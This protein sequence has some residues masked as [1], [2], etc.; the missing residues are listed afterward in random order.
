MQKRE[1]RML[2]VSA[3]R[4]LRRLAAACGAVA[5][6]GSV[7]AF[8]ADHGAEGS[9]LQLKDG[10]KKAIVVQ[11][12]DA[13]AL[14]APTTSPATVGATVELTLT[15]TQ[16][17]HVE[18]FDLPASGWKTSGTTSKYKGA[19]GTPIKSAVIKS[20]KLLKVSGTPVTTSLLGA[21]S[22][23]ASVVMTIGDD[24][25]CLDFITPANP[26]TTALA[27]W[28]PQAVAGVCPITTTTT[29]TVATT[30]TTSTTLPPGCGNGQLD[31]GEQC[32][33]GNLN[34][35]D[36][37]SPSCQNEVCGNGTV[38]C[39][40]QCDGG[41]NC[42]AACESTAS[43]CGTAT[44]QRLVV[45]SIDTPTPLAGARVQVEYPQFQTSIPG[46]GNSSE[47]NSRFF[48]FVPGSYQ[49]IVND[50][51]TEFAAVFAN[52]S[53]FITSGFLYAVNF[54]ECVD[55][56]VTICNRAQTV[57]GCCS[58]PSD[59]NQFPNRCG[60]IGNATNG[61]F[62]DGDADCPI[63]A[64][65]SM[66]TAA[67]QPYTCCTGAGTGTCSPNSFCAGVSNP[68]ACCTGNGTGTCTAA[69][70]GGRCSVFC[71]GNPPVCA[72]GTFPTTI[73]AGPCTSPAGGCPG[74]NSCITQI[75]STKCTISNPV[76]FN[77]VD[78][79]PVDGVTCTVTIL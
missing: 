15:D 64:D 33:D 1:G 59:P 77:G 63:P 73:P 58:N 30:T 22:L 57:T 29:T 62:C 27:K 67:G 32:D 74:E 48:S 44:S 18:T 53:N 20:G 43:T 34:G 26:N 69:N 24:V 41:A 28:G 25:Y 37:C 38:D 55:Q 56:S 47:V 7:P 14:P 60:G 52:T 12:K 36:G 42:N 70:V 3:S 68:N 45:V 66:C 9:Q 51:D 31:A 5:L 49:S 78:A 35:C 4:A 54:D 13:G 61:P 39:G 11:S 46:S 72:P 8:A 6:L 76:S 71:P 79:V 2:A 17:A 16:G 65:S 19:A 75:D 40:E 10:T 23:R 21:P 50:N